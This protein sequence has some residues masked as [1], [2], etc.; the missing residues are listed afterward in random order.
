[1]VLW[2]LA[3]RDSQA[4]RQLQDTLAWPNQFK[5]CRHA[6]TK[7][8]VHP[9][10]LAQAASGTT[11]LVRRLRLG[12]LL[13]NAAGLAVQGV[14]MAV[15]AGQ[16]VR[17]RA[18]QVAELY[19][20]S[21]ETEDDE[22]EAR[23]GRQASRIARAS[24]STGTSASRGTGAGTGRAAGPTGTARPSS[25]S[26][27]SLSR[28]TGSSTN[29]RPGA[30]AGTSTSSSSSSSRAPGQGPASAA[31]RGAG[32]SRGPGTGA[33]PRAPVQPRPSGTGLG[34][35][36]TS[37]RQG[38]GVRG[39]DGKAGGGASLNGRAPGPPRI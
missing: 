35:A 24:T 37:S 39:I 15:T 6:S 14:R 38:Q 9:H 13:A 1:M 34:S 19:S 23:A 17:G 33:A 8:T 28:D 4:W 7:M 29:S 25:G 20:A 32:S 16:A 22:Y 11:L 21:W 5:A 26:P 36:G 12:L 18:V 2:S 30:S 3:C 31:P 10:P 27:S